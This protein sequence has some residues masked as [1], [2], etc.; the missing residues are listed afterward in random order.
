MN[1]TD[2]TD[3]ATIDVDTVIGNITHDFK[4][5]GK[6]WTDRLSWPNIT[7]KALADEVTRLRG[8]LGEGDPPRWLIDLVIGFPRRV[9]PLDVTPEGGYEE[10]TTRWG[11]GPQYEAIP[12]AVRAAAEAEMHPDAR[13]YLAVLRARET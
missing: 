5:R 4:V 2:F 6:T 8:L 12:I 7:V 1:D 13:R 11:I 9:I 3:P 10:A